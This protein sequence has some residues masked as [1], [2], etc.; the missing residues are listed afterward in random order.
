MLD[1]LFM[2]LKNSK[3]MG[4]HLSKILKFKWNDKNYSEIDNINISLIK[5]SG[6]VVNK[7]LLSDFT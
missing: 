6:E 1:R 2:L 4:T 7:R 5:E 3:S